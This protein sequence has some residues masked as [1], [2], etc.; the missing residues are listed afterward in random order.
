M[1]H[2]QAVR[3]SFLKDESCTSVLKGEPAPLRHGF[4]KGQSI[5]I[6][7]TALHS[8]SCT[9]TCFPKADEHAMH[10]QNAYRRTIVITLDIT[11]SIPPLISN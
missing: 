11:A 2:L 3:V 10:S 9:E 6:Q 5:S 8:T 1:V 4:A 7:M